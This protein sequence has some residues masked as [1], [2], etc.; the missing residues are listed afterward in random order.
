M[1]TPVHLNRSFSRRIGK[2]LSVTQ[3][4]LLKFDLPG[5]LYN[6]SAVDALVGQKP[7]IL[8]IGFGMGDHFINQARLNPNMVFIGAEPYLNGVANALK[9]AKEQEVTNFLLWPDDL[10]IIL[11]DMPD[12]ILEGI[13]ILFHDPWPKTKQQKKRI[14]NIE[15]LSI[16]KK[17]LRDGGFLVFASDIDSYFETVKKLINN[18]ETFQAQSQ[19]FTDPP[20][21]YV[22]TK[23]HQKSIDAGRIAR[24]LKCHYTKNSTE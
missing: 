23:Y 24:F 3:K 1:R 13:Y 17:K 16:F 20:A 8:E 2:S 7:L 4:N 22:T 14:L 18:D 11:N 6:K 21:N 5:Y 19:D 15:R 12:N 10:D 9:L